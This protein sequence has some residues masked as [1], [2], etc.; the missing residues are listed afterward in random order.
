RT[1]EYLPSPRFPYTTLFRSGLRGRGG[2]DAPDGAIHVDGAA[3][4]PARLRATGG[5]GGVGK[6]RGRQQP[7]RGHR[8]GDGPNV[9]RQSGGRGDRKSTRLNSSHDQISY[10][11]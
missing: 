7:E 11:V 6:H 10:A 8:I 2:R 1:S 4:G 5:G 9:Q 3:A